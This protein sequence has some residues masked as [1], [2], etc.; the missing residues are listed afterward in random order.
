MLRISTHK[1]AACGKH[2]SD[3]IGQGSR[4]ALNCSKLQ[5]RGCRPQRAYLFISKLTTSTLWL[6]S[7]SRPV[8]QAASLLDV[9]SVAN[10]E[11]PTHGEVHKQLTMDYTALVAST[12]ELKTYWIP[13]KVAQ[14]NC[15][16]PGRLVT[17][18]A[19]PSDWSGRDLQ[20]V[21]SDKQ[22]LCLRLRG[23]Q[24]DTWLYLSWHPVSGRICTGPQPA[25]GT[26][27]EAFSFG[28]SCPKSHTLCA[29]HERSIHAASVRCCRSRCKDQV[30]QG[31]SACGCHQVSK[32]RPQSSSWCC[33]M[34]WCRSHGN[35]LCD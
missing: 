22:T 26:A 32:L 10:K 7:L 25:R 6:P 17:D 8:C 21:Q 34:L 3:P 14:V 12:Q 23:L 4:R 24:G 16:L 9:K 31:S 15:V 28:E 19:P 13:A 29:L 18:Y 20:C 2:A 33:W 35:V 1:T 11:S 30:A 27:A 5:H